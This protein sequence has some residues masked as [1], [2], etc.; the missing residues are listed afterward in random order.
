MPDHVPARPRKASAV[1]VICSVRRPLLGWAFTLASPASSNA[2]ASTVLMIF[3]FDF[4]VLV[5]VSGA[6]LLQGAPVFKF[7]ISS[8]KFSG[9]RRFES[10]DGIHR[11]RFHID[12]F[13]CPH[14][15]FV[16]R[17]VN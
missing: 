4:S 2:A 1:L 17:E 7:Q 5:L 8:L 16:R 15:Q 12:A 13:Q 10:A 14:R 6:P 3:I 11:H 9:C